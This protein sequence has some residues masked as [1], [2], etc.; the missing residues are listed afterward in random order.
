MEITFRIQKKVFPIT[1]LNLSIKY[2]LLRHWILLRKK[3]SKQTTL[4]PAFF[5]FWREDVFPSRLSLQKDLFLQIAVNIFRIHNYLVILFKL[6]PTQRLM[7]WKCHQVCR[8]KQPFCSCN[9]ETPQLCLVL[10]SWFSASWYRNYSLSYPKH[11]YT[12]DFLQSLSF[13]RQFVK[14]IL[15]GF[16]DIEWD[17][18]L[19]MSSLTKNYL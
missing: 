3:A 17:N 18:I 2:H 1:C 13:C 5:S 16:V 14:N 10:Q 4:P 6:T 9:L 15:L 19:A 12:K 7:S 11:L 8:I